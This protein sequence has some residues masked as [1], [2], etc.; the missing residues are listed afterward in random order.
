MAITQVG[1]STVSTELI[2]YIKE[3][4]RNGTLEWNDL[5][6]VPDYTG[7]DNRFLRANSS[8][9]S[10]SMTWSELPESGI[11]WSALS[12]DIVSETKKGYLA[13]GGLTITMP[14]NPT[15]GFIVAVA[16][17]NSEFDTNPTLVK[18]VD[19]TLLED[20]DELLLDI[21]NTYIQIIFDGVKWQITQVNSPFNVQEIT[22]ETFVGGVN[23]Y[24]LSRVPPNSSALL[25]INN[26]YV[27]TSDKYSI[28]GNVLSFGTAPIGSI[29]VR[30]IGVPSSTRVS[31]V[32][33]GALMY[34]PSGEDVDGW[35]DANG[36]EIH[37]SVYPDLV[38][39]LT[40]DVNAETAI[41]P[42]PGSNFLKV[43]GRGLNTDVVA[44]I[45]IPT[46]LKDNTWG[47]WLDTTDSFTSV[48][49]WDGN[50]NTRTTVNRTFGYVGYRFDVPVTV[51]S[52]SLNT[53]DTVS[54]SKVPT[55]VIL[56][57]SN[58][59]ITWIN[60]SDP[61]GG[62]IQN[63]TVVLTSNTT[64][65]YRYWAVFGTGGEAYSVDNNYYWGVTSLTFSGTSSYRTVGSYQEGA[66]GAIDM[67][68]NGSP[69]GAGAV[70]SG[71]GATVPVVGGTGTI[72]GGSET[73]PNNV[74]YVLK[75]KAFHYQSGSLSDTNVIALRDE[76]SRLSALVENGKSY[77]SAVPPTNPKDGSRWYDMDSGRT[78]VWFHD[79]DSYQWVD[80]SPQSTASSIPNVSNSPILARETY[81]ERLLRDRFTDVTNLLDYGARRNSTDDSKVA[82]DRSLGKTVFIPDGT[83]TVSSGDYTGNY[84][85]S[86]GEVNILGESTGIVVENL[87]FKD[88][89]IAVAVSAGVSVDKVD[90]IT[91][92]ELNGVTVLYD[93]SVSDYYVCP[94]ELTGTVGSVSADVNGV[95]TLTIDAV[96]YEVY[97]KKLHDAYTS[98]T[99]YSISQYANGDKSKVGLIYKGVTV[100][101]YDYLVYPNESTV[102]ITRSVTGIIVGDFNPTTGI[103]SG[104]N[105]FIV[106][107]SISG[108]DLYKKSTSVTMTDATYTLDATE[109]LYGRIEINGTL[110]VE[111]ELVVGTAERFLTVKNNTA[112]AVKVVCTASGSGVHVGVGEEFTFIVSNGDVIS[113]SGNITVLLEGSYSTS[114]PYSYPFGLTEDNIE[115]I[116]FT[117][118]YSGQTSASTSKIWSSMF[119]PAW[120]LL[121]RAASAS[122]NYEIIIT[123]STSASFNISSSLGSMTV[124]K[125]VLKIK[126]G[127]TY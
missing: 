75:I 72:S 27:V 118:G 100:D 84:Y 99:D 36:S 20:S 89:L 113:H 58:D 37:K 25:I 47:K 5:I 29:Y 1:V 56:K 117:A 90:L 122:S 104:L 44:P 74:A 101:S 33:I 83:Y 12:E 46:Y 62:T 127:V 76:V 28:V 70:Q 8:G 105:G 108:S 80:D 34:F 42:D 103:D 86:F 73:R 59:G 78:Y 60:T 93:S 63:A 35:L 31:D 52:A 14:S 102:W 92:T 45:A 21:R 43:W 123:Q 112:F 9:G 11:N 50:T 107:K 110:T 77:V 13:S 41:L 91:E 32:P 79:G 30:H 96:E 49:L 4:I 64:T 40:K 6:D 53:S 119:D 95:K 81:T 61:V 48:N 68:I 120:S 67:T 69:A 106:N 109:Q 15:E 65:P 7:Q 18:T 116:E 82:F 115:Y 87:L 125:V 23:S 66:V 94:V 88:T 24:T 97:S 26:G 111:Q 124:R 10:N 22:E 114:G 121:L 98:V 51:N 57:A 55:S 19:G 38:R 71:T 54:V 39:Y 126:D 85:Y 16:D 2:E 17:I 3:Q